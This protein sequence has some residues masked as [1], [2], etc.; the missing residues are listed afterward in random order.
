MSEQEHSKGDTVN[1]HSHHE[2]PVYLDH[3]QPVDERVRDLL[4]HMTLEEKISQ[5]RHDAA[6]I[7]HLDIPAYNFWAEGQRRLEPGQFRITVGGC[8]SGAR[9]RAR[10]A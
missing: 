8:S 10:R 2:T 4:A 6:A 1:V 7:P 3:A 9:D 5:M